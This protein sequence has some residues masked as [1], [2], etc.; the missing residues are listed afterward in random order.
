MLRE[1]KRS[2]S[3]RHKVLSLILKI[4]IPVLMAVSIFMFW[5]IPNAPFYTRKVANSYS[6]FIFPKVSYVGNC[7][8]N[9][10]MFSFTEMIVIVGSLI[11]IPVIVLIIA[12]FIKSIIRKRLRKFL[13]KG[14]CVI[15]ALVLLI[16]GSFQLMH[17]F[18]YRRDTAA[19]RMGLKLTEREYSEI[20]AVEM[21]AYMGMIQARSELGNDINGVSHMKTSFAETVFD[22]N[23]ALEYINR[24]YDLGMSSTFVRAKPVMISSLWSYTHIIGMYDPMLGESNI[25]VDYMTVYEF[26]YTVC[27]EL[28]HAKGYAKEYD[29]NFIA[30]IAC[31]MS[32]RADFRYSGYFQIFISVGSLLGN[33]DQFYSLSEFEPVLKDILADQAYWSSKETGR[34]SDVVAEVSEASNDTYLEANGQEGGTDTYTVDSNDYVEYFYKWI[35]PELMK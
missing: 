8:S 25:N 10:F 13:Y 33:L 28:A 26:P 17:G 21:W 15:L 23:V 20:Y 27:H 1:Y 31:I 7:F 2:F 6:E 35:M 5:F 14:L 18:N 29:A 4:A 32:S 30:A 34:I 22:A 24:Q 16:F 9:I 11:L 12:G 19:A 3:K